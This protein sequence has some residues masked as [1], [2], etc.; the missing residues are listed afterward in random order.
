MSLRIGLFG[1]FGSG[2]F[3]NDGSLEA[4]I[5][6]LRAIAPHAELTAI[7]DG[8]DVI[9]QKYRIEAVEMAVPYSCEPLSKLAKVAET[10]M[11][12]V[13][14]GSHAV[15]AASRL[16]ALV[17]PGTG[18][19]DDFNSS[20]RGIPLNLWLWCVAARLTRTP[21]HF[22]SIGAGPIIDS[23]SRRLMIGAARLAT[24]R[25]YR[26]QGSKTFLARLGVDTRLDRVYPDLA[27][28]LPAPNSQQRHA[29]GSQLTVGFGLMT[30][31]G[32][33][34]NASD[35][36]AT[37]ERYLRELSEFARDLLAGG[38]R[39]RVL[40]GDECDRATVPRFIS[41]LDASK[42]TSHIVHD[43]A[44]TLADVLKQ[45]AACDIIVATRFHNIVCALK[46]GKP[47][48]SVGYAEKNRL[49]LEKAGLDAYAVG[50]DD[51]TASDLRLRFSRAV[52]Q[53]ADIAVRLAAFNSQTQTLLQQQAAH[54]RALLQQ[55]AN[56]LAAAEIPTTGHSDL[57]A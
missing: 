26:D 45:M 15:R 42:E 55:P 44:G 3:G 18:L 22:V 10:A 33:R 47:V 4:M 51:F 23:W 2:N 46:A 20:P 19:L 29:D 21:I 11:A 50:I 14:N 25:S 43:E 9:R 38:H 24:T 34:N 37:Y 52:A 8:P 27:F 49:L 30:Y 31:R 57:K 35:S 54:L 28:G 17:M 32:W 36:A 13:R 56:R 53:R 48:V 5:G 16:D 39:L 6:Q 1:L 41:M 40:I 7:C 12:T